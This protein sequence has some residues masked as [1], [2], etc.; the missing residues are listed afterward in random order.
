MSMRSKIR[1]GIGFKL[2][3]VVSSF[4][5]LAFIGQGIY[6]AVYDYKDTIERKTQVLTEE[7][8]LLS[9]EFLSII[10][11]AYQTSMDM[12]ATLEYELSFPPSLRNRERIENAVIKLLER[13]KF[14]TGLG[15]FFEPNAFD[16]RDEE[17]TDQTSN[18]SMKGRFIPYA[19]KNGSVCKFRLIPTINDN[20]KNEWYTKPIREGRAVLLPP[21]FSSD[22]NNK[23]V[24]TT[25]AIPI[26]HDGKIIGA[27]NADM[28]VSFAQSRLSS[29]PDTSKDSFKVLYADNG[30]VIAN[31]ADETTIM[32]NVLEYI[33]HIK[34][35]FEAAAKGE[36]SNEII[37]SQTTGKSSQF[38]FVP[39]TMEE[40][41]TNWVCASITSI[42]EF[43]DEAKAEVMHTMLQF[44]LI[45]TLLIA[46]LYISIRK[47]VSSPLKRTSKA[48]KNIAQGDGDLTVRLPVEGNDEITELSLY[49]NQTIEKIG[50]SVKSID[51][52]ARLMEDIGSDLASNMTETASSIHEISSNIESVKV[53]TVTQGDAV[54]QTAS[55]IEEISHTI[56]QL[57][58]SIDTQSEN[59]T[60][61]S[62]RVEQM[63][64]NIKN[65]TSAIEK[66]Y[67]LI[68][69]LSSATKDG[70][71]TI[72]QSNTVT[73]KIVEES[74][75]LM[76]ASSV[77]QHIASQTNLLAMNAAIEAAHAGEA[78]KGFAVV[79][80]E[81]RKLSEESASQGKAITATLK[82]LSGELE[83][84]SHSSKI[85]ET[86]F[87]FIFSLSD[88]INEISNRLQEA[89][90]RQ[91]AN[92]QLVLDAMK[93]I[94]DVTTE[95]QMGSKEM[96]KG[97]DG[98][99]QEMRKLDGLTAVITNSMNEM[100]AGALQINDAVHEVAE[101]SQKNKESIRSLVQEVE[102]FKV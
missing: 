27:L 33:P 77:I 76:E 4:L 98:I 50:K 58:A 56:K 11:N 20:S 3:L 84:L 45:L 14:L 71:E 73:A 38:I 36:E 90:K 28:D 97:S 7:N 43:T 99:L 32:K 13:N 64:T 91:D 78:G 55:T 24:H 62:N 12:L 40:L 22:E 92:S 63:V 86:K 69:E 44:L 51:M 37:V 70:K 93:S 23:V 30:A 19:E 65:I 2:T 61:S 26:K 10:S 46:I 79:A 75:S 18:T 83:G 25:I 89:M 34:P 16:G 74:G 52:N 8:R 102:Q 48:L 31:G 88:E 21:Y 68:K 80:D 57:N 15:L 66:S 100:A 6:D 54:S 82:M 41:N 87:N 101:I 39:V 53:Q 17:F 9:R 29:F 1:L 96:L 5:L 49:F 47:S 42:S 35:H 72:A 85:V 59:I 95:V 81:I 67:S 60:Q 94:N